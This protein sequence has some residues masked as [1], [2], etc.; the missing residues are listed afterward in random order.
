MQWLT[1]G[2]LLVKTYQWEPAEMQYILSSQPMKIK[3]SR[4]V[5]TICLTAETNALHLSS[6]RYSG[7]TS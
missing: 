3:N 1:L 6:E 5:N 2:P 7:N 4:A